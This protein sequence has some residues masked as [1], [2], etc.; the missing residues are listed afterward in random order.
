VISEEFT[1]LFARLFRI[2]DLQPGFGAY[3]DGLRQAAE[4]STP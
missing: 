4:A 1:G 2:P 3:A